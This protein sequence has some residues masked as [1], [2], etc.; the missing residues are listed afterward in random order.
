MKKNSLLWLSVLLLML[1]GC[2]SDDDENAINGKDITGYWEYIGATT[3]DV[4]ST[5]LYFQKDGKIKNWSIN[6]RNEYNETDWGLW[7]IE[8]VSCYGDDK[9]YTIL[10]KEGSKTPHPDELYYNI[11][12]LTESRLVIRVYGGIAG[13]PYENGYDREYRKLSVKPQNINK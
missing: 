13:T 3:G 7:W 6:A 12:S 2:S 11:I 5:G 4:I 8:E 10:I 9:W 1:A